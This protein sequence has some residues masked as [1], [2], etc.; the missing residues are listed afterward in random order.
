MSSST[1]ISTLSS[2]VGDV[3]ADDGPPAVAAILSLANSAAIDEGGRV[4][5]GDGHGP[6]ARLPADGHVRLSD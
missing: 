6:L 4:E 3:N 5:V 1:I 2:N